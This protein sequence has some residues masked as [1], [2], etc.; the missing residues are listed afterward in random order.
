[1]TAQQREGKSCCATSGIRRVESSRIRSCSL[2]A[3]AVLLE[4]VAID[5]WRTACRRANHHTRHISVIG[6]HIGKEHE[7]VLAIKL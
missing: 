3:I 5:R 2:K 4:H 6:Q 1:M 7:V